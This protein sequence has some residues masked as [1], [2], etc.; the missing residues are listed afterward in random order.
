VEVVEETA[1]DAGVD[2]PLVLN[3]GSEGE[4]EGSGGGEDEEDVPVN[5]SC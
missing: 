2:G 1:G 4:R 3:E 5:V